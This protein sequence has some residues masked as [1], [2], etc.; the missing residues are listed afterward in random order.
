MQRILVLCV[1]M[2][3]NHNTINACNVCSCTSMGNS[4]GILPQFKSHFIGIRETYRRYE[5]VHPTSILNPVSIKSRETYYNTEIW[6]RW[7]PHRKIQVFGFV[8]LNKFNKA[9]GQSNTA[10]QG[11]GDLSLLVNYVVFNTGDSST[12]HN[13]KQALLIGA[14]LKLA[15]GRFNSNEFAN[16]QLGSGSTDYLVNA[17]YTLR[18]KKMGLM[19][20]FNHKSNGVNAFSYQFGNKTSLNERLFYFIN[21]NRWACLLYSA[22][23]FEKSQEDKQN[24]IKQSYTGGTAQYTQLGIDAYIGKFQIGASCMLPIQQNLG[25]G[26]IKEF[27]R[28]QINTIFYFNKKNKCFSK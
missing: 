18:F 19:S 24:R 14:G 15:S 28:F 17:S 6:G 12:N 5:S 27:P 26:Q 25:G 13:I 16:Y 2:V 21:K 11:L 20:E 23:T 8:P 9:E 4:I 22:Y 3:L 1:F 10:I 7:Y